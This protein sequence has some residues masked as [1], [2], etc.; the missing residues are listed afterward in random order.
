VRDKPAWVRG[1]PLMTDAD[2]KRADSFERGRL[3]TTRAVED[4]MDQ[5]L[6]ALV[7]AGKLDN[8]Y[9]FFASDNGLLMGEHRAVGR[10]NNHYE[11]SI[12]VPLMVRGPGVPAGQVIAH[13]VLNI[14]LAPTFAELARISIPDSVDGRSFAPLLRASPPG[15]DQWRSDFLLEHFAEGVSSALRTADV[16]YAELESGELEFYDM[17]KDPYQVDSLHRKVDRSVLEPFSRR[18]A[19]LANCRGAGCRN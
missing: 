18:L 4:M 17:R 14:D 9:V 16:L 2:I 13:P 7:A 6:A 11:E 10:K 8:T 12:R 19:A 1:I 3:R 15:L 5:V